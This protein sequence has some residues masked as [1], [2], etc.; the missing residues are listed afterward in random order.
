MD[1][2]MLGSDKKLNV[3]YDGV[4]IQSLSKPEKSI[5]LTN[6]RYGSIE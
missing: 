4:S 5:L 1:A 2:T 6:N 3:D